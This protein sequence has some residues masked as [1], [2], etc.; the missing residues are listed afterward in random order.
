MEAKGPRRASRSPPAAEKGGLHGGSLKRL[1]NDLVCDPSVVAILKYLPSKMSDFACP[2]RPSFGTLL[3][4]ILGYF[5]GH[6]LAKGGQDA[7][8]E[9]SKEGPK[10]SIIL[11]APF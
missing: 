4:S 11:G 1:Q 2:A 9:A 8:K 5:W 7:Q 6:V 3:G 10:V